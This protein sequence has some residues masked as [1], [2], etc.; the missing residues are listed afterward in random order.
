MKGRKLDYGHMYEGKMIRKELYN[1]KTIAKKFHK[2]LHDKDD[3]P[4]WV[5]KKVFLA[6]YQLQTAYNYIHNKL[7]HTSRT[8]KNKK[9]KTKSHYI[10]KK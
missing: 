6:N 1:I 7:K 5:N 4:E 3:L 9:R 2:A 10:R 8:K